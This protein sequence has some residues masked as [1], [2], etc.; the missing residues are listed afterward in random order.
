M[1]GG[2]ILFEFPLYHTLRTQGKFSFDALRRKS[3]RPLRETRCGKL[4]ISCGKLFGDRTP[5]DSHFTEVLLRAGIVNL[6]VS[7]LT[8]HRASALRVTGLG[9]RAHC[10]P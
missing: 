9:S 1:P 8:P 2:P 4:E 10:G 6:P 5:L 3:L 7:W